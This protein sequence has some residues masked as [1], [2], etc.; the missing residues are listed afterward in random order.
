M[1][2]LSTF[3]LFRPFRDSNPRA[4][5]SHGKD[6]PFPIPKTYPREIL[7]LKSGS[8]LRTAKSVRSTR[9]MCTTGI[10]DRLVPA[11]T[12]RDPEIQAHVVWFVF[13]MS[14]EIRSNQKCN[15]GLNAIMSS[16]MFDSASVSDSL[17]FSLMARLSPLFMNRSTT[18]Y[19]CS[20][21][22]FGRGESSEKLQAESWSEDPHQRDAAMQQ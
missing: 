18:V 5:Y 6:V 1:T 12:T 22:Y 20:T 4:S 3:F 10:Y 19:V 17:R 13:S 8:L 16:A 21:L 14:S 11:F 9:G 2:R 15:D 7:P